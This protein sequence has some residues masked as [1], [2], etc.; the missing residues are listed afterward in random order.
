[1]SWLD[2]RAKKRRK[3]D[4]RKRKEINQDKERTII[5]SLYTNVQNE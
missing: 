2:S 5:T 1:M 3:K 4:K